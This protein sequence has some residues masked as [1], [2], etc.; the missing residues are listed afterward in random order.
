VCDS[1]QSIQSWKAHIKGASQ[2]LQLRG[3]AQL[4]SSVGRTLFREMRAQIVSTMSIP[5]LLSN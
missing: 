1:K 5:S 4:K 3:K 2:L